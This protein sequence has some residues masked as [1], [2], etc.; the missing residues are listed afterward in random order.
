MTHPHPT[1]HSLLHDENANLGVTP[2]RS[3]VGE[4]SD[5]GA[6]R[7]DRQPSETLKDLEFQHLVWRIERHQPLSSLVADLASDHIVPG[8]KCR[9]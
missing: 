4:V 1:L 7:L 8:S 6:T 5:R 2:E 3:R 9:A